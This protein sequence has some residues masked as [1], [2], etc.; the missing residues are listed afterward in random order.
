M[1]SG[2]SPMQAGDSTLCSKIALDQCQ[3][4]ADCAPL[5]G[6][7]VTGDP[8]CVMPLEVVACGT[9]LGCTAELSRA[10]DPNGMDWVFPTACIPAGWMDSSSIGSRFDPCPESMG[11]A[12]AGP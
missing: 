2:G 12:G 7:R 3:S 6:Q 10:T 8:Q 1:P 11:A 5:S 4:T 9:T